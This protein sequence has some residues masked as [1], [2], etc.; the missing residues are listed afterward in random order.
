MESLDKNSPLHE[1]NDKLIVVLKPSTTELGDMGI[2]SVNREIFS[3]T[4]ESVTNLIEFLNNFNVNIKSGVKSIDE[5][6]LF[7]QELRQ[8]RPIS[9]SS[10]EKIANDLKCNILGGV[11]ID[12][13]YSYNIEI[14]KILGHA[15]IES[16]DAEFL[17]T[18]YP[19]LV[20]FFK[21]PAKLTKGELSLAEGIIYNNTGN[22]KVLEVEKDIKIST[23]MV[24]AELAF[25]KRIFRYAVKLNIKKRE[26]VI[27][28]NLIH[29]PQTSEELLIQKKLLEKRFIR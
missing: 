27:R 4:L 25:L 16:S 7:N 28:D 5:S 1:Q 14:R 15:L 23:Q 22:F 29:T 6:R 26:E 11:F 24:F 18:L 12:W 13:I 2:Y 10:A 21:T 19:D 17:E 20:P 3:V 9:L 8:I